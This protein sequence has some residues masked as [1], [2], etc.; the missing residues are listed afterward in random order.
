MKISR[1][2]YEIW[3][4]DW[5]DNNLGPSEMEQLRQFLAENPDLR[6]EFDGMSRF[7]LDPPSLQMPF[8][9][10][11][12]KSAA[13][14]PASQFDLL[15]VAYHENDLSEQQKTDFQEMIAGDEKR[16]EI[17][18][19][20]GK[21]RLRPPAIEFNPKNALLKRTLAAK[22]IR[23][24]APVLSV[25]AMIALALLL[26][27]PEKAVM[28]EFASSGPLEITYDSSHRLKSVSASTS[29][30]AETP[31]PHPKTVS[32]QY[33]PPA[34]INR[35]S[36]ITRAELSLNTELSTDITDNS[37]IA[38]Q[39]DALP[40][41]RTESGEQFDDRNRIQR[42]LAFKFREKILN[43][44]I[45][46]T[47]PIKG[48]DIAEASINGLNKLF[49]WEMQLDKVSDEEDAGAVSFNSRLVKFSTPVKNVD[50]SE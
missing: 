41:E 7:R 38:L 13:D 2:N 15:C 48:F 44:D 10:L 22:I 37:L 8:S 50:S 14:L 12:K 45:P 43:E 1:S 30:T 24:A 35:V 17:F 49:G 46:D 6:E 31:V 9:N 11:L 29:P 27:R 47:S 33:V 18:S 26:V 23:I 5:L 4:T 21:I 39:I 36:E 25:A 3:F 20:S 40:E 42:L 19:F 16:Q 32:V 28:Q 34:E